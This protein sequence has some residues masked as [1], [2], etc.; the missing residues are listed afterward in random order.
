MSTSKLHTPSKSHDVSTISKSSRRR[1]HRKRDDGHGNETRSKKKKSWR[2]NKKSVGAARA[3][4]AEAQVDTHDLIKYSD[5]LRRVNVYNP[6]SLLL[7]S[8]S[9]FDHSSSLRDLNQLTGY[10][11]IN[12]T[13]ND[14]IKMNL[15]FFKNFLTTQ[16]TLYEQQLQSIQPK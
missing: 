5:V 2:S 4:T 14:L 6:S 9:F 11:L 1:G 15:S 7:S 16:R 12:E 10:N 3:S 8:L 13:F